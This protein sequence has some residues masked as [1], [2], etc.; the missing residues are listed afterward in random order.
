M[1]D[2]IREIVATV[3]GVTPDR[4]GDDDELI[5]QHG[6]DSLMAIDI[7]MA[8]ETTFKLRIPDARTQEFVSVNAIAEV[9]GELA[10][11]P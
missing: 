7:S 8:V 5:D 6:M 3:I 9:V 4:I 11:I 10:H 2:K 1:K